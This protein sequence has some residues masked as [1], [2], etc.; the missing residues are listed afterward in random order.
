MIALVVVAIFSYNTINAKSLEDYNHLPANWGSSDLLEVEPHLLAQFKDKKF[1]CRS[2]ESDEPP[3]SAAAK[4]AL[5]PLIAYSAA[6]DDITDYWMDDQHRKKRVELLDAAVKTGGWK[7]IYVDSIWS[8]SYRSNPQEAEEAAVQFQK[9]VDQGVPLAVYQYASSLYGRDYEK[10]YQMLGQA[11]DRGNPQAMALVGGNIVPQARVLHPI[12][13]EMLECA[14]K[15]GYAPAYAS[16]GKLAW[17]EGRRVDA[18]RLWEKGVNVGCEACSESLESLGRVRPGYTP[19]TSMLEKMPELSAI[20]A[21]YEKNF[22]YGMTELPDF[23]RPLPAA[24]HFHIND[25]E[26]LALLEKE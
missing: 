12:G 15:K 11:V 25:K 21:F 4:E 13:R 14:V 10:M 7:A 19:A 18:Y 22:F 6:G 23:A 9:L 16:L 26:L 3:E 24:L 2:E 5:K 1:V 8:L 20:N 17:M